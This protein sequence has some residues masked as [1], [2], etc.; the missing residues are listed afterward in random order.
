MEYVGDSYHGLK[1]EY[2]EN[3]VYNKTNNIYSLFFARNKMV[4]D[5]TIFVESDLIFQNGM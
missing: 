1:I 3:P 4:E 2:V 5:D